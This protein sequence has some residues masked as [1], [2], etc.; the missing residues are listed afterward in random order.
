MLTPVTTSIP[1]AA[2][3]PEASAESAELSFA[4]GL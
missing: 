2:V 3:A 1:Q 4:E